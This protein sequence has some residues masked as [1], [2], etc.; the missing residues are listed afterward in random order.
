M[1][2]NEN[3]QRKNDKEDRKKERDMGA[4]GKKGWKQGEGFMVAVS[5]VASLY[6]FVDHDQWMLVAMS[7]GL[8][9]D[10]M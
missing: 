9:I 1:S 10:S 2:R 8:Y 4:R 3:L 7:P 6:D 5:A